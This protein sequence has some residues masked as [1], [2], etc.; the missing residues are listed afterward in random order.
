MVEFDD[1]KVVTADMVRKALEPLPKIDGII[2]GGGSPCQGLSTLNFEA[3][4]LRDARSELFY[5]AADLLEIPRGSHA[6]LIEQ[7]ELINL[8]VEKWLAERVAAFEAERS[9][10]GGAKSGATNKSKT[11]AG[12]EAPAA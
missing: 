2:S 1:I 3:T 8:R 12:G 4:G 5:D 9:A 11:K 10:A 6:A 7:P